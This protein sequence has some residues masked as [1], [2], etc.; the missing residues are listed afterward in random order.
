MSTSAPRGCSYLVAAGGA[1]TPRPTGQVRVRSPPPWR[2][3][4][5]AS[6][7]PMWGVARSAACQACCCAFFTLRSRSPWARSIRFP[8]CSRK[9][10]GSAANSPRFSLERA[11]DNDASSARSLTPGRTPR[12]LRQP[13][14]AERVPD[15]PPAV[16][17]VPDRHHWPPRGARLPGHIHIPGSHTRSMSSRDLDPSPARLRTYRRRGPAVTVPSPGTG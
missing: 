12:Q 4:A 7:A 1:V 11:V 15:L 9:L 10:G 13:R 5:S 16:D 17:P 6:P 14:V 2:A 3:A 8:I